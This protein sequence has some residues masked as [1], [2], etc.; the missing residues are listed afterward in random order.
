[1]MNRLW[2]DVLAGLTIGN[3]RG[4]FCVS[5]GKV[6]HACKL[7]WQEQP[8]GIKVQWSGSFFVHSLL[9]KLLL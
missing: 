8:G 9:R 7:L 2:I 4:N 6:L 1:M 3:F 5:I